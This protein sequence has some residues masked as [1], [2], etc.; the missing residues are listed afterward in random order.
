[1]AILR[2]ANG[3]VGLRDIFQLIPKHA[4]AVVRYYEDVMRGPSPLSPGERELV[5]SYCSFLNGCHYAHTSHMVT[6][7]DLGI[8]AAAFQQFK[9]GQ[10]PTALRPALL[11]ILAFAKRLTLEPRTDG[12]ADADAIYAA[13][14]AEQAVID[15]IAVVALTNW[16]NRILNGFGATAPDENHHANG[17]RM[18]REGYLGIAAEVAKS[19]AGKEQAA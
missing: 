12:T 15:T 5:Y 16:V 7:I 17:H 18:A 10:A 11:P 6:A 9:A 14:W 3:P 19:V 1:M 8:D 2:S 13:G 4:E